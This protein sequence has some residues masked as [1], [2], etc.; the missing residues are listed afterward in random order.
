MKRSWN[1]D[2]HCEFCG[3]RFSENKIKCFIKESTQVINHSSVQFVEEYSKG[4]KACRAPTFDHTGNKFICHI[5]NYESKEK[6]RLW[7]HLKNVHLQY[8][9]LNHH[10]QFCGKRFSENMIKC[11]INESTQVINHSSV[12]FVEELSK[13]KK[14]DEKSHL[15]TLKNLQYCTRISWSE[16]ILIWTKAGVWAESDLW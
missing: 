8:C 11:F 5:C 16:C 12:K 3:K 13:E 10:C 15:E 4:K 7:R 14:S 6:I 9:R 1:L 2:H